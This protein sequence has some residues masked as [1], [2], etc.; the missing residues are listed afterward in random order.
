MFLAMMYILLKNREIEFE[1]KETFGPVNLKYNTE[2]A[3]FEQQSAMTALFCDTIE[4]N[5]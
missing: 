5:E 2:I 4:K 1:V 3:R